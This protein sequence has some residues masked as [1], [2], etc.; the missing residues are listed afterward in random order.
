MG[1]VSELRRRNVFRMAALYA[2]AAWLVMQ[3]VDVV[4][5]K[6]PLPDWMGS[7][8]LAV[9]A[10]GFPIALVISWFY[11]V[12]AEGISRDTDEESK[13][14]LAPIRIRSKPM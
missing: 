6:L 2:A 8:V 13:F 9:L 12:T 4:E 7:A 3:V 14:I 1:L 10:V 11:E 5:G